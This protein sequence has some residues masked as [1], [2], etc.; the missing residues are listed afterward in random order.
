MSD[1]QLEN[2]WTYDPYQGAI[3]RFEHIRLALARERSSE[4]QDL[5]AVEV[6]NW[7]FGTQL[8][9]AGQ[10]VKLHKRAQAQ[11]PVHLNTYFV[12]GFTAALA[13]A[14]SIELG[15]RC[16][17]LSQPPACPER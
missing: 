16:C 10:P 8:D 5:H 9:A 7:T 2:G 11:R 13:L 3:Y 15:R 6:L 17:D 1:T 12:P 14:N 4:K